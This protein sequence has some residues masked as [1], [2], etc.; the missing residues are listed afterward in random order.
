[1]A[2]AL[3]PKAEWVECQESLELIRQD[4]QPNFVFCFPPL[5]CRAGSG[6]VNA[7]QL[8]TIYLKHALS[9]TSLGVGVVLSEAYFK[10]EDARLLFSQMANK[11]WF[12]AGITELPLDAFN[13]AIVPS[14]FLVFQKATYP[15]FPWPVYLAQGF[16]GVVPPCF[17]KGAC[18]GWHPAEDGERFGYLQ[19]PANPNPTYGDYEFYCYETPEIWEPAMASQL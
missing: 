4:R 1:M 9:V 18:R 10:S 12:M 7:I 15:P 5:D 8:E 13:D 3:E 19:P 2:L 16:L 11:N 17:H 14:Y 6:N